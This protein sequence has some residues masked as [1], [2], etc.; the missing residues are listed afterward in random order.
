M[1]NN[2]ENLQMFLLRSAIISCLTLDLIP[3]IQSFTIKVSPLL[4]FVISHIE[5]N[6]SEYYVLK[7]NRIL[8]LVLKY[9]IV[10]CPTLYFDCHSRSASLARKAI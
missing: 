10:Y 3:Y 5:N 8:R 4:R 6:K 1:L 7:L 9:Q 2:L